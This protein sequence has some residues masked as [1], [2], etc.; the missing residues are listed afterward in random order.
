M[1]TIYAR[2][3]VQKELVWK[4]IIWKV[5]GISCRHKLKMKNPSWPVRQRHRS[6]CFYPQGNCLNGFLPMYRSCKLE[7]TKRDKLRKT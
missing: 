3:L 1:K 6:V 5:R 2:M 7:T 4:M